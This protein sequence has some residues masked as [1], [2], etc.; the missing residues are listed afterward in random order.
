MNICLQSVPH[1]NMFLHDTCSRCWVGVNRGGR[2][3]SYTNLDSFRIMSCSENHLSLFSLSW[4]SSY[5]NSGCF[6]G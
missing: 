2:I 3:F 6:H 1:M 4:D 5:F